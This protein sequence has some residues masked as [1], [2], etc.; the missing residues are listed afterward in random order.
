MWWLVQLAVSAE[1]VPGDGPASASQAQP[2]PQATP[3]SHRIDAAVS[4]Y[5]AG[6]TAQARRILQGVLVDGG[7][8]VA[9][10][11]Q[12]AMAWLGDIQF[13]EQGISAAQSVL[14][15]LLAENPNYSMD[16]MVHPPEFC[17]AFERLRADV[18]STTPSGAK[19][20][21]P[22][23]MG[24]PFGIGYFLDG[25]PR[26]GVIVGSVQVAGIVTSFA[27]EAEL[28]SIRKVGVLEGDE[29]GATRYRVIRTIGEVG[30]V[31]AWLAWGVPIVIETASW[32]AA[33]RPAK[34]TV[35]SLELR[36][37]GVVIAG[38]F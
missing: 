16:P 5:L 19:V 33:R 3:A 30:G 6:E 37:D 9:E 21:Y 22:W 34:V 27:A 11:R 4:L 10:D 15:S 24:L 38:S 28:M 13:A 18:R 29:A 35:T 17:E 2:Q 20:P 26:A 36:P 14:A 23:Q 32:S 31:G 7:T 25:R 1:P 12:D 8:L